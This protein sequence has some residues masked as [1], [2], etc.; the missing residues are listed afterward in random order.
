MDGAHDIMGSSAGG[1]ERARRDAAL[2]IAN[3]L[4]EA[5]ADACVDALDHAAY[6]MGRLVGY[7]FDRAQAGS[8]LVA[9]AGRCGL[10]AKVG[11]DAVQTAISDCMGEGE[12]SAGE[13]II[14]APAAPKV[15]PAEPKSIELIP[16]SQIEFND[17]PQYLVDLVLPLAGLVIVWGPP[18]SGK[19]FWTFDLMM[20]VAL[21]R[22][23]R[24]HEVEQGEVVYCLFEGQT[25]A[26]RRKRA[27]DM[28]HRIEPN[29]QVPFYLMPTPIAL[30][31]RHQELIA[32]IRDRSISPV[33]VVLD[34]LN[35]SFTG[36]ESSDEDMG[37]YIAAADEIKN[38]FGCLVIIIHHCGHDASRYRGHSSL[39]G[40]HDA[41]ISVSREAVGKPVIAEVEEMKDGQAGVRIASHLEVVEVGK[42]KKHGNPITSC[43]VVPAEVPSEPRKR[44]RPKDKM[45]PK[46]D[47]GLRALRMALQEVGAAPPGSNY[48]I[49]GSAAKVVTMGELMRFAYKTGAVSRDAKAHHQ[50][51]DLNGIVLALIQKNLAGRN[52]EFLWEIKE[53][54]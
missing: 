24:G 12:K 45:T 4:A 17:D 7:G 29:E 42:D 30:V 10:L 46:Q 36:K 31:S 47:A 34:T 23:Y 32:G 49:Q 15:A 13:D 3:A 43:K 2:D 11:P 19:S 28:Q 20:H 26:G 8:M 40:A 37:R 5:T 39:G 9:S 51:R 16:Y 52:E 54:A 27:F 50:N 38:A 35:R 33:C 21:G 6:Q 41:M 18:K 14:E 53:V 44:G 22:E 1:A 25:A 48:M